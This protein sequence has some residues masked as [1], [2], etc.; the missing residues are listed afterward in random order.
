MVRWPSAAAVQA[1]AA[2]R[3]ELLQSRAVVVSVVGKVAPL[4][5]AGVDHEGERKRTTDEAS[6]DGWMAS[7]PG[8]RFVSWDESGGCLLT[9]QAV[10]GVEVARAWSGLSH[11]TCEACAPI[12]RPAS[13]A[14]WPAAGRWSESLQAAETVRGR[15]PMRGAAG[16]PSRSSCEALRRVRVERRGRVVQAWSVGQP[17]VRLGG[18]G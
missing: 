6:K 8:P 17:R 4:S 15:V 12:G 1:E 2:N 18:A 7:K 9:G 16:G 5:A 14:V 11:G 13:G 10:S 3:L